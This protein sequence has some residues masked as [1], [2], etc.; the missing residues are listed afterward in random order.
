M[1]GHGRKPESHGAILVVTTGTTQLEG[2]A[3]VQKCMARMQSAFPNAE[4]TYAFCSD[5]VRLVLREQGEEVAGPL[6]AL[7]TLIEKGHAQ[8]VVQPLFLTP[9]VQYHELY[10][11]ITA[12][13]DLAGAHGPLGFDGILIGSPLFMEA[14]DYL[15]TAQVLCSLYGPSQAGQ[16]VVLVSPS[17]EGGADPALCQLQ[18]VLDD[19]T[20]TGAICIGTV[21][22]YPDL[23]KVVSRLKHIGATSVRLVPLAVVP[24]IHAWIEL[25]GEANKDSWQKALQQ[26]GF[27]VTVDT[28]GL[29]EYDPIIDLYVERLKDRA[30][31]HSF[32]R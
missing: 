29:G 18:M 8:I 12:L 16:A 2:R 25:S 31:S 17:S 6:A 21:N 15:E 20:K 22:G 3:V 11:I 30:A 28:A 13:N 24:G 5:T 23:G 19:V 1:T 32:L 27:S 10:P 14:A 9:G 4:V 7:A 26:A